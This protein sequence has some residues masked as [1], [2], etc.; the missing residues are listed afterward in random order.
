MKKRDSVSI[1]I[2]IDALGWD[3]IKDRSFLDDIAVTKRP[4]KSILGFSSGVIP[5]ILTGKY[6]Q[7]HKHWSLYFYSPKTS[8]FHWTKHWLWLPKSILHSRI[9]RKII[10]EISKRIMGY[11]G[12]FE[13]YAIQVP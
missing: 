12:Y 13:T 8:P 6:P 5:S 3:Y 9:A 4:V 11:T 1:F 2:L 10:E 7:E